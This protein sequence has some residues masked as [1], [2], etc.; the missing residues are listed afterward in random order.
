MLSGAASDACQA[1]D[2]ASVEPVVA[3]KRTAR[4][5]GSLT[6]EER[7]RAAEAVVVVSDAD[8]ARYLREFAAALA[9]SHNLARLASW[10]P[11]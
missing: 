11:S 4:L 1:F 7:A 9:Q 5:T 10:H 2:K 8:Q 6:A 3:S